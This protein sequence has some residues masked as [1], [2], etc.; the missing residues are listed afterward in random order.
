MPRS[1][2][3]F[4]YTQFNHINIILAYTIKRRLRGR[5]VEID[6]CYGGRSAFENDVFHF[7]HV[8]W[9][10]LDCL[11]YAGENAGSIEMAHHQAMRC[12]R[13]PRQIDDVWNLTLLF[14]VAND[15]YRFSS[16]CF[17]GLVG[18]GADVMRPVNVCLVGDRVRELTGARS[19][20]IRK[21]IQAGA[22]SSIL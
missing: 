3:Y 16:D 17:L 5:V 19:W 21:N 1:L 13:L 18:G 7:L 9:F 4:Q 10:S 15:A 12:R 8:D 14:K 6:P 11:E 2:S 20:F 22:Q